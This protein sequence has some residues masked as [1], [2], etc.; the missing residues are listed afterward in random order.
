MT[1]DNP[2]DDSP[3]PKFGSFRVPRSVYYAVYEPEKTDE[4]PG[5][6]FALHGFGQSANSFIRPLEPARKR[7]LIVVAAQATNQFYWERE[8]RTVGF[9][10]MTRYQ[11]D[12]ALTDTK[13]YLAELMRHIDE[14]YDFD[15]NRIFALGFSQGC[16]MSFRFAESGAVKLRGLIAYCG[17]LPKDVEDQLHLLEP[18]PVY[19]VHGKDDSTMFLDRAKQANDA[20]TQ[21]GFPTELNYFDG[22][23]EM[24]PAQIEQVLDWIDKISNS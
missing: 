4:R 10:W 9:S 14:N 16:A 13:A 18:F 17:D 7:N 2:K 5:L 20:L 1:S 23:H 21:H 22:G 11:L 24:P 6:L 3:T 8:S 19:I 12:D 15:P